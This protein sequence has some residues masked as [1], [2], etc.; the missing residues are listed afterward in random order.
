[1]VEKLLNQ[2]MYSTQVMSMIT[3]TNNTNNFHLRPM[4]VII[5]GYQRFLSPYKGFRCAHRVLHGGASCSEYVR[6]GLLEHG[7]LDTVRTLPQRAKEC[8]QAAIILHRT[9]GISGKPM[10]KKDDDEWFA[11]YC[12]FESSVWGC[13]LSF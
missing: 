13:F 9:N 12:C 4:V 8:R 11:A 1:M 3:E 7:L 2:K 6:I 10:A 5:R